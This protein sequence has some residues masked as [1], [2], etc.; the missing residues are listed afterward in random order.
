MVSLTY[1]YNNEFDEPLRYSYLGILELFTDVSLSTHNPLIV[2]SWVGTRDLSS[3]LFSPF[4]TMLNVRL[5]CLYTSLERLH[6]PPCP[7]FS[8]MHNDYSRSLD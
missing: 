5:K 7:V 4:Q 8:V 1:V 2:V 6:T 3:S